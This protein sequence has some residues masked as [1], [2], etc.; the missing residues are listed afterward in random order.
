LPFSSAAIEIP[1]SQGADL[2]SEYRDS[3]W[4]RP[5]ATST[6]RSGP[7][8]LAFWPR[9]RQAGEQRSN[10]TH[11]TKTPC[12]QLTKTRRVICAAARSLSGRRRVSGRSTPAACSTGRERRSV[13]RAACGRSYGRSGSTSDGSAAAR[14]RSLAPCQSM[15]MSACDNMTKTAYNIT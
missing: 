6:H 5:T 4:H 1:R 14:A 9:S 10:P 7:T 12:A 13:A 8:C 2:Y 11:L 15:A 3:S